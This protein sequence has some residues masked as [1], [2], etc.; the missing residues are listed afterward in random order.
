MKRTLSLMVAA[1]ISLGAVMTARAVESTSTTP[2]MMPAGPSPEL[3][4][5]EFMVGKV[6]GKGK[7]FMPGQSPTDWSCSDKTTWTKDGRYLKSE[8]KVSYPGMGND[9]ALTMIA[10]DQQAKLYHLWRFSS[11]TTVP[12]EATGNFD[13]E[14]LVFISSPCEKGFIFRVTFEPKTKGQ[15]AFLLEMKTGDSFEKTQEGIF[16]VKA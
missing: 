6:S 9:E 8:S 16:S 5:L 2:E 1:V 12:I 14:K 13:G 4:K 10:Y 3:K 11:Y 7:M 15:V